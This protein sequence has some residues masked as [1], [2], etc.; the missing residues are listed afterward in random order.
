MHISSIHHKC[1]AASRLHHDWEVAGIAAQH[2]LHLYIISPPVLRVGRVHFTGVVVV[3]RGHLM[4]Q[5][6][7][8]DGVTG[9][10]YGCIGHLFV[11]CSSLGIERVL[12]IIISSKLMLSHFIAFCTTIDYR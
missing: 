9:W 8:N 10:S 7:N 5:H 1:C 11:K 6:G 2:R 12:M 3:T 4:L